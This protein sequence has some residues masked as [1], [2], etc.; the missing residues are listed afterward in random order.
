MPRTKCTDYYLSNVERNIILSLA[1]NG[2]VRSRAAKDLFYSLNNIKYHVEKIQLKT[3]LNPMDFYD[4]VKLLEII[5]PPN[6]TT[7]R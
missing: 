4:M 1:R 2:L 7:P 6:N 5:Q 3:G